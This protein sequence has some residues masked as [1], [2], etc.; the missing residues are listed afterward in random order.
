MT[1]TAPQVTAAGGYFIMEGQSYSLDNIMVLLE[2]EYVRNLD[3]VLADQARE[4][5]IKNNELA[6]GQLA[7]AVARKAKANGHSAPPPEFLAFIRDYPKGFDVNKTSY[8]KDE[9]SAAI[10][11]LKGVTET[12]T[13][14]SQLDM[15]SLQKTM[16]YRNQAFE[17]TSNTISKDSRSK[18]SIIGNLR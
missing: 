17:K 8:N 1:Q 3:A 16:N 9:W 15:I 4:M 2:M 5:K 13:S 11:N 18:D 12:M 10:E 14:N 6:R 7:M